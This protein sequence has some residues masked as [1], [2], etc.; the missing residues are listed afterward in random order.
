[1]RIIFSITLILLYFVSFTQKIDTKNSFVFFEAKHM[2]NQVIEGHIKGFQGEI[3]FNKN[4]LDSSNINIS[5]DISTINT[6]FVR[7]DT[8][9]LGKEYFNAA[10]Y[11]LITFKSTSFEKTNKGYITTGKLIIKETSEK[12]S[13]PFTVTSSKKQIILKGN[14]AINRFDFQVGENVSTI[15]VSEKISIN[16]M[17]I[18]K[19]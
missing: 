11:P 17:C 18:L 4:N 3:F 6:D 15:T 2:Q 8:M 7:R 10:K 13:I 19:K 5:V 9:L 16:I 1:M 12:V 14:F